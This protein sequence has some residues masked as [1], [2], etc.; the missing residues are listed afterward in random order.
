MPTLN[1]AFI[2]TKSPGTLFSALTGGDT[3]LDIRWLVATDPVYY[4][5]LNRPLAD[6]AIRQLVIAKAV[7]TVELRLGY[8]ALFPFV[9]QPRIS[10]STTEV[11]VPIGLIWDICLSMPQKWENCRLAKI[12][13]I[14]GTNGVTNGYS[15]KLRFIFTANVEDSTTEVALFY[16]DY[17]IDSDLTY[18]P[19]RLISVTTEEESS[20]INASEIDTICGFIIFKTLDVSDDTVQSF[21]DVVEPPTDVTDGNSDGYFDSPAIYELSDT[22]A[23]GSNVTDDYS[24]SA[25]SHGTGILTDSA[26]NSIP[27]IDSDI[28]SWITTFNYP[29]DVTATRTSVDN[30]TIPSGLFREFNL[31]APA[32]DQPSGDTS[33][34][35]YPVWVSRIEKTGTDNLL[36]FYF[37]TYNVTDT[38]SGGSPSTSLVEFASLDLSESYSDGDVVDIIPITNLQDI[39]SSSENFEQHF[40][41]G[42]VVLS[43]V[44][45]G[46]T[47]VIS[48]F[49]DAFSSI[50]TTPVD[51]SFTQSATRISSFGLSRIPKYVPTI[52]QSRA[53]LGSTS[54]RATQIYPSYD[55]RYITEQDQGLGD[56]IDLDNNAGITANTAIDRY[57]YTGSLAH[58]IVKLVIDASAIGSDPNF[59]T[60][61]VLPR[62][63]LLF[64]R[65]PVFGDMWFN[66]SRIMCYTGDVWI[67]M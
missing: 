42:H 8:Q 29:Y 2:P 39:S 66:G 67:S 41:R 3:S 27:N 6:L 20:A 4:E 33:G 48:D 14:S 7:D 49:F 25:L 43:S 52:G 26:I 45:D 37:A 54:R 18:Q 53:L 10:S 17:T 24:T 63:R 59:Y 9:V 15:G 65:D 11:D 31:T 55:N 38:A 64:G 50:V 28:Q 40:G 34:T 12:K 57:G 46:T 30:I 47:S 32:G 44:W 1:P 56:A 5:V 36:R 35:Y 58:R 62:L 22:V 51:T 60:T 13:R 21:L 16:A 61:H 19:Q 23:G